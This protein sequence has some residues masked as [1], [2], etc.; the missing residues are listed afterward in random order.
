MEADAPALEARLLAAL[1]AAGRDPARLGATDL[2]G[3]DALHLG[4]A[5]A[6]A[7]ILERLPLRP[8]LAILDIGCGAGGTARLLAARGS[9]LVLGVDR[10]PLLITLARRL[11]ARV[12]LAERTRFALADALALP[13]ADHGFDGAVS[14]H[15]AMAVADKETLRAEAFRVIRP[16][17][18]LALYDATA[19]PAGPPL[20][21]PTPWAET[22]AASFVESPAET[23]AGL[24]RV[25]FRVEAELD[26]TELAREGLL[27]LRA[28]LDTTV[29]PA[30]VPGPHLLMGRNFAEKLAHVAHALAEDRLRAVAFL[31]R[32]P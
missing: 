20:L 30:R 19:G 17:G 21:Y 2:A 22:A 26:L 31:A 27:R 16:G 1:A 4:G 5:A 3:L 23:R 24:E 18:F 32:K 8:G 28:R 9:G 25:G 12:G 7:Q 11:A 15:L 14:L 13:F 10:D 29:D 6:S